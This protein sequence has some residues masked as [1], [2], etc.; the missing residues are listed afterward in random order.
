MTSLTF[1]SKDTELYAG[2]K[3]GLVIILDLNSSKVRFN[4]EA[5]SSVCT[6]LA[7]TDND[8]SKDEV[9]F[10]KTCIN[11]L[12]SHSDCIKAISIS[13]DNAYIATGGEDCYVKVMS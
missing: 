12:K 5:H 3:G 13:N 10:Q 6:Q 4:L 7:I 9:L 8:C 1:N 2:S 11:T